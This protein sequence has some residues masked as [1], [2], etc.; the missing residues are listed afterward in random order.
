MEDQKETI[1]SKEFSLSET[2][3][4]KLENNILKTQNAINLQNSLKADQ[5][6]LVDDICKRV[7]QNAQDI[8][9]LDIQKGI[10]T[11]KEAKNDKK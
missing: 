10:V 2:E 3:K 7:G 4:L 9:G 11:F 8:T 6:N 1:K 5:N